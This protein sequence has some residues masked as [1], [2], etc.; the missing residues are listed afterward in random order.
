MA[1]RH[2]RRH[3]RCHGLTLTDVKYRAPANLRSPWH[4]KH[5]SLHS[6]TP[7][8]MALIKAYFNEVAVFLVLLNMG[9]GES[10]RA[11][12]HTKGCRRA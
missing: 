9:T 2:H 7:S 12:N 11:I 5:Q 1:S 10:G 3:C 8:G 6:P 4:S